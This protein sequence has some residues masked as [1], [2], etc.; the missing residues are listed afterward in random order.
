MPPARPGSNWADG[1]AQVG[2]RLV[3]S[4][5]RVQPAP[6]AAL[7]EHRLHPRQVRGRQVLAAEVA[8]GTEQPAVRGLAVRP[9]RDGGVQPGQGVVGELVAAQ[10]EHLGL[11]GAPLPTARHDPVTRLHRATQG[12]QTRVR[13]VPHGLQRPLGGDALSVAGEAGAGVPRRHDRLR[14]ET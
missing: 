5:H 6:G 7:G 12:S 3:A 9:E 2:R 4:E 1:V 11:A 10:Q 13:G 14:L 8:A